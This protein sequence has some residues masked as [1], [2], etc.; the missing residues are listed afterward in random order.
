M[1]RRARV[2]LI[3]AAAAWLA[4]VVLAP[5]LIV[6]K[7][8]FAE[9]V[10]GR[11][12]FTPLLVW[13][14]GGWLPSL[15]LNF[16]NY[17]LLFSDSLYLDAYLNSLRLAAIATAVALLIGLPMAHAMARAP[18]A[19]RPAL[20]V[21]AVLPFWT[22]SLIRVYAWIG[23]LGED[24]PLNGAL[25]S[26]GVIERPLVILNTDI[27]IVSGLVYSYL[28]F[29]VLPL[30]AALERIDPALLEAAADLGSRP[31]GAFF[32]ITLP[33]ALPGI[34][35]G[36]MLVFIPCVG[37]FVVP[38]LMG[39]SDTLM[40]G[41]TLWTEFFNNRDWPLAGAASVLLILLLVGPIVALERQGLKKAE[42][43]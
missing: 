40:I 35:A 24:G 36:S 25:L 20:L 15:R 39:G 16:G 30:Y 12:P 18:A 17:A 6:L 42:G 7:I 14:E 2:L 5:F 4:L 8:S 34:L 28:P 43:R 11:P 21:L 22:S 23:I 32:R 9:V 37:E 31:V 10:L 3:S 38:D 27:G 41:K 13:N 33:L 19:W 26:V 29:M 1:T